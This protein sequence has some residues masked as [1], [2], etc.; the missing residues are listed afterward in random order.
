MGCSVLLWV[1]GAAL[2]LFLWNPGTLCFTLPIVF[3]ITFF[4][5]YIGG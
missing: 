1:W 2:L 5:M 4:T 3:V